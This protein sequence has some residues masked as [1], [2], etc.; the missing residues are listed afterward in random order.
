MES[1]SLERCSR[2]DELEKAIS[3]IICSEEECQ[4]ESSSFFMQII[5]PRPIKHPETQSSAGTV[6]V[7]KEE[8]PLL[9]GELRSFAF[10]GNVKDDGRKTRMS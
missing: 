9:M 1:V 7:P 2:R 3:P 6:G 5:A 8:R 10:R 4:S